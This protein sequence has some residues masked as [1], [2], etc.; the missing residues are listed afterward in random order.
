MGCTK[1]DFERC[2]SASVQDLVTG[3]DDV[4]EAGGEVASPG[5]EA[6][7]DARALHGALASRKARYLL[8]Q[9]NASLT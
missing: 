2:R 4:L 7:K 1:G 3:G 8:M 9:Q 6:S 5:S